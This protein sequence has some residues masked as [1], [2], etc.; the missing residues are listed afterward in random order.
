MPL[1]AKPVR[2]AE[3]QEDGTTVRIV[4][5]YVPHYGSCAK[6]DDFRKR[7]SG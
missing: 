4:D 5:V 6:A 2:M 1:D 7:G 3:L